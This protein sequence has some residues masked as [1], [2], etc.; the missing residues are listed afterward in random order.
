MS[1]MLVNRRYNKPAMLTECQY[2]QF[3]AAGYDFYV[4]YKERKENL[5]IYMSAG[6]PT[7]R[8]ALSAHL[9]AIKR[10]DT[11]ELEIIEL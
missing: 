6:F 3:K 9:V 8:D 1:D 11:V 7:T 10:R 2:T 5:G 4:S